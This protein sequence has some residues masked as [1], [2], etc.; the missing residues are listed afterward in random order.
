MNVPKTKAMLFHMPQRQISNYPNLYIDDQKLEFVK[1]FNF[2]GLVFDCN[3]SWKAH[4]KTISCKLAKTIGI[5]NKL[6]N[7]LPKEA[8][9]NIYNSLIL[10]HLSYGLQIWGHKSDRVFKFQKKAVRLINNSRYNAHTAP[11]FKYNKILK[12]R[13]MCALQDFNFCYKLHNNLTP[14]YF[15][16]KFI[17][18]NDPIHFY[19]TRQTGQLRVPAVSHDFARYGISY[20]Y[21]L[22]FNNMPHTLKEKIFTHSFFGF[23]FYYKHTTF[24]TYDPICHIRNC[25][26]CSNS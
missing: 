24:N 8:L 18:N 1:E 22:I 12:L 3:L 19:S 16:S 10:P 5:L 20:R 21:P 25:Y 17:H 9:L 4:L 11:L 13:D 26:I 7:F 23:K 14:T 6:K 15:T 2:L